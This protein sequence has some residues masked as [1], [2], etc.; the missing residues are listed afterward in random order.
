MTILDQPPLSLAEARR[1]LAELRQRAHHR[2]GLGLALAAAGT[3]LLV[4]GH[5]AGIPLSIGA[6]AAALLAALSRDDRSR[7]LVRLVA[8][9]DAWSIPEVARAA[10]RL[11]SARERRR[12]AEGLARAAA[13]VDPRKAEFSLVD[14]VRAARAHRRLNGLAVAFGDEAVAVHPFGA[15]LCR[16]LLCDAALSPLYNPAIPDAE[17]DRV[18]DRIERALGPWSPS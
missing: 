5:S 16:R 8:Q 6:A 11:V 15:A 17:L 3:A 14:A 12:L 4:L 7:L 2:L 10:R 13:T 1:G 18:I 9:G